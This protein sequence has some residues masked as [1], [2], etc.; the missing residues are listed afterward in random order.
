MDDGV[1]LTLASG[2]REDTEQCIKDLFV[3]DPRDDKIRIEGLKGGLLADCYRWVLDND[4]FKRW[5]SDP[6]SRLLWIKG[7][8]GK[9]KTMLLC[10]IINELRAENPL[11]A[12]FFCQASNEDLNS[13]VAVLRGLIYMLIEQRGSLVSHLHKKH[14]HAGKQTFEG[15]NAWVALRGVFRAMLSDPVAEG[16]ILIIDALDECQTD[17]PLLLQLVID[18]SASKAR[19]IVSS[20]N[21]LD[22]EDLESAN[23]KV[24]LQLELNENSVTNAVRKYIELEVDRLAKAKQYDPKTRDAVHHHLFSNAND[25]F[26]W[27]AIVCQALSKA[28][29]NRWNTLAKLKKMFPADLDK[30][31]RRMLE[32]I[33]TQDDAQLCN[34]ILATVSVTFRPLNLKE[35]LSL[36]RFAE[37]YDIELGY[38]RVI[39]QSCGSFIVLREDTD[40]VHFIHQSAKEYLV[41]KA[42]DIIFPSHVEGVHYTIFARSLEIL[43]TD[44]C[45]DMYS[46]G[47]PGYLTKDIGVRDPDPIAHI[48]YSCVHWADHLRA[49]GPGRIDTS[50]AS[51]GPVDAFFRQKYLNWLEALSLLRNVS[52][53]IVAIDTIRSLDVSSTSLQSST[54]TS[55]KGMKTGNERHTE[56]LSLSNKGLTQLIYDARRFIL[57][58]R[59]V[60]EAAPLQVY[61]SALIFSPVNSL[62]RELYQAEQDIC[63]IPKDF[64]EIDWDSCLQTLELEGHEGLTL[65]TFAPDGRLASATADGWVQIWDKGLCVQDFEAHR[66]HVSRVVFSPDGQRL[67]STAWDSGGMSIKIWN[68]VEERCILVIEDVICDSEDGIFIF[69]FVSGGRQILWISKRGIMKI[70]DL[71]TPSSRSLDFFSTQEALPPNRFL[72]C[73]AR[74]SADGTK[75]V[76]A[77]SGYQFEIW[78]LPLRRLIHTI[79]IQE[80]LNSFEPN[81]SYGDL[82]P[83]IATSENGDRLAF[84]CDGRIFLLDLRSEDIEVRLIATGTLRDLELSKDGEWVV[85]KSKEGSIIQDMQGLVIYRQRRSWVWVWAWTNI[86]ALSPDKKSLVVAETEHCLSIWDISML[87]REEND[88]RSSHSIALS[89][90]GQRVAAW[91]SH[92]SGDLHTVEVWDSVAGRRIQNF[93]FRG[94]DFRPF[95]SSDVRK[96]A[97]VGTDFIE[98]WNIETRARSRLDHDP[99]WSLL[100]KESTKVVFE[101]NGRRVA[102]GDAKGFQRI[103]DSDT[104]ALLA[105]L[106]P[107]DQLG[108]SCVSYASFSIDG[109]HFIRAWQDR[110]IR[111][112]DGTCDLIMEIWDLSPSSLL[113]RFGTTLD[114]VNPWHSGNAA[115]SSGGLVA[116]P[117]DEGNFIWIWDPKNTAD[118]RVIDNEPGQYYRDLYL[119]W[120]DDSH[121]STGIGLLDISASTHGEPV[122]HGY[123]LCS[124]GIWIMRDSERVLWVHPDYREAVDRIAGPVVAF[125]PRW[126]D[127]RGTFGFLRFS[128]PV[129]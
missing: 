17:L 16:A 59:G 102:V 52:A 5:H 80:L 73:R 100:E 101:K 62:V 123:H 34:Q 32:Y 15:T 6:E 39:I 38:L 12:F 96:F 54:L 88:K 18:A 60:I 8:P 63:T 127:S 64:T 104:G 13:A 122:H 14:R 109:K 26:L 98:I 87:D 107:V 126:P 115:V 25:T 3:T 72:N 78:D 71:T 92:V 67:A 37:G 112:W 90:D 111:V 7:D 51:K 128:E 76:I 129:G 91:V 43:S 4:D 48:N 81:L 119:S 103:C 108:E 94:R 68:L 40:T 95:F 117:N 89:S 47:S 24:V 20:R 99:L 93:G 36:V 1:H 21:W 45:R 55:N 75:L 116:F 74:V 30:L 114:W 113:Q 118:L 49:S 56:K 85:M 10:G 23:R 22:F 120:E 121:L 61:A 124:E 19:C 11:L 31:Y 66:S 97:L 33:G 83:L 41:Q 82:V 77:C 58:F 70:Q 28:T 65:A 29:V 46:L 69:E 86:L 125:K 105:I 42:S 35:L 53:A 57:R 44:L 2:S 110:R 84:T 27:V 106:P 79:K 9:G 50:L